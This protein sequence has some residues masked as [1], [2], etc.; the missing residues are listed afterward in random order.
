M[1]LHNILYIGN[2]AEK[3]HRRTKL[4]YPDD[5]IT[6]GLESSE[7]K[8]NTLTSCDLAPEES[9]I[10]LSPLDVSDTDVRSSM[11][12][13]NK[14]MSEKNMMSLVSETKEELPEIKNQPLIDSELISECS[15]QEM[16]LNPTSSSKQDSPVLKN[17]SKAVANP[18]PRRIQPTLI[19]KK[20]R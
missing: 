7:S 11:F 6:V 2:D 9:A 3:P 4:Q 18:T 5:L 15:I 14:E 16:T 20:S 10:I 12:K 19:S 17:I 8:C 1:S 13:P